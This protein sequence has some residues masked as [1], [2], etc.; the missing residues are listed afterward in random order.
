MEATPITRHHRRIA[1]LWARLATVAAIAIFGAAVAIACALPN[2][3]MLLTAIATVCVAVPLI[4]LAIG[5]PI[6][7]L[8]AG[9]S[10]VGLAQCWRQSTLRCRTE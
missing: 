3:A 9:K 7:L 4:S 6:L 2:P 10:A 1:R 8:F 5:W